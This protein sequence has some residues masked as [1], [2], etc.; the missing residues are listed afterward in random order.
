LFSPD[1]EQD[2]PLQG[3]SYLDNSKSQNSGFAFT[4]LLDWLPELVNELSAR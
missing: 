3:S 1:A 2:A 4:N